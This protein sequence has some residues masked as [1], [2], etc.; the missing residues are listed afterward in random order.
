MPIHARREFEVAIT[1]FERSKTAR[2]VGLITK[3]LFCQ[4]AYC[5][6]P[7]SSYL[8]RSGSLLLQNYNVKLLLSGTSR[9]ECSST[10]V[11]GVRLTSH[12]TAAAF[13]GLLSVP[14]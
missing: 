5:S 10:L 4:C 8:F 6:V 7:T 11:T 14:V 3:L 13:T 2:P 1:V 12:W 9:V